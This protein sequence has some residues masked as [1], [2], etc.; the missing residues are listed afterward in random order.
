MRPVAALF[1]CLL[2]LRPVPAAT[3]DIV[4][5]EFTAPLAQVDPSVRSL[6]A[7][8]NVA[9]FRYSFE[10]AA[11]PTDV[12]GS[13]AHYQSIR[14]LELTIQ[15]TTGG[16]Y[17][18]RATRGVITVSN[19]IAAYGTTVDHY[20][21]G[22]TNQRPVFDLV[23]PPVGGFTVTGVYL[24][25]WDTTATVYS[26]LALPRTVDPAQFVSNATVPREGI[27]LRFTGPGGAD[28]WV[29]ASLPPQT[30][31]LDAPR[32]LIAEVGGS[33]AAFGWTPPAGPVIG[34]RLEAGTAP[35][36]SNIASVLLGP[37]PF[38]M[39]GSVPNGR[40]YVRV[41]A[42]GPA[43]ES[44]PSNEISVTVGVS[45][46]TCTTAPGPP[47]G[48]TATVNATVVTLTFSPGSGCP[49]SRYVLHAGTAP[50]LSNVAIVNLGA[51]LSLSASAPPGVYYVRA[52]AQN[53]FGSSGPSNEVVV[54]VGAGLAQ[55]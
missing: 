25:L 42:I 33:S 50:G 35:G 39:A 13:T 5:L 54:H 11:G 52:F 41:R 38:F 18:A 46:P 24:S 22:A 45:V 44:P 36:L 2:M 43:G 4:T 15:M 27:S 21:A 23:A 1:T 19:N 14:S 16:T 51:G 12:T 29:S 26:S 17:V 20:F 37:I 55:E 34:Y 53:A 47:T 9:T 10:A 40:Y 31:P 48:L 32:N 8:G 3:A 49:A 28:R 7:V 6:F 30:G